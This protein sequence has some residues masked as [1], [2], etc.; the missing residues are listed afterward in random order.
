MI[1]FNMA[2]TLRKLSDFKKGMALH[3]NGHALLNSNFN[4]IAK[5]RQTAS[6]E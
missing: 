1:C 4:P 2:A 5:L 3:L 6:I